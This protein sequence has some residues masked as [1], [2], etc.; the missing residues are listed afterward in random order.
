MPALREKSERLTGYLR[1]W[2]AEV[3]DPRAR[4]LT[5]DQPA[6]RGCQTSLELSRDGRELFRALRRDGVVCDYRE[7]GVIRIAPVPLYNSFHDVWRFGRA[8]AAWAAG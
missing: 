4:L 6:A 2:I 7:P 8:L 3:D 1:D 5:P